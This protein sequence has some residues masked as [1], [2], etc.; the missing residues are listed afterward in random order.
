M[1]KEKLMEQIEKFCEDNDLRVSF[2]TYGDETIAVEME[3]YSDLGE[4]VIITVPAGNDFKEFAKNL[5]DYADNYDIDEEVKVLLGTHGGPNIEELYDEYSAIDTALGK[6]QDALLG[7][8]SMSL[9]QIVEA[10]NS[11]EDVVCHSYDD[12][13]T[14][15]TIGEESWEF[16]DVS[17]DP[18]EFARQVCE[19]YDNY[20]VS[21]KIKETLCISE[22]DVINGLPDD[23]GSVIDD[24]KEQVKYFK[25]LADAADGFAEELEHEEMGELDTQQ[26]LDKL[27]IKLNEAKS[28]AERLATAKEIKELK[29]QQAKPK[30][31]K[32][33]N[34]NDRDDK[35]N[36]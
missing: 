4:D 2:G 5:R 9:S 14:I 31:D 22:S 32:V 27:T 35:D 18:V 21:D 36:R 12:D 3:Y 25:E 26:L 17:K 10:I 6:I 19:I 8:G 23:I 24:K 16:E 33:H 11:V 28:I 15:I 29:D 30:D 7:Y 34:K 20:S 13:G 1:D